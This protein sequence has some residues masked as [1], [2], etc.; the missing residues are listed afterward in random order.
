MADGDRPL[1]ALPRPDRVAARLPAAPRGGG[2]A[3]GPGKARQLERLSPQ[4]LQLQAALG[5]KRAALQ[6]DA[7][8]VAPELVLVF[9][10]NGPVAE[11]VD[12]VRA[13]PGLAWLA[14]EDLLDV[15]PDADFFIPKDPRK[16]L[17]ARLYMVMTNQAALDQLLSLWAGWKAN[18][19]LPK[20]L[21]GWRAVFAKLRNVRRWGTADRLAETGILRDWEDRKQFGASHI[22]VEVELWFRSAEQRGAAAERVSQ[23]V[24][25]A[26][27]Q[28]LQTA[29]LPDIAY[30]AVLARLPVDA[31]ERLLT[32]DGAALVKADDVRL[33]H[34]IPQARIV[35]SAAA[36]AED[37]R[38]S[39]PTAALGEPVV[40]LLDG[41]PVE[42][43][44]ELRGRL[45]VEDPDGWAATYPVGERFHGTAMASLILHGDLAAPGEPSDRRL[46]VRP[47]L[48]PD[49]WDR[50]SAPED[51]LWLD[52]VHRAIRRIIVGD[53][54]AGPSA[55]G[56]RI[57]NLSVGDAFQPFVDVAVSPLARLID[58]L[59]WEHDLLFIVSAGNHVT[60]LE[61][62]HGGEP[63]PEFEQ[64]V[65]RALQEDHRH[66]RLLSPAESVNAVTVGAAHQDEGGPLV[67]RYAEERLLVTTNGMPSPFSALG[68]G[69]RKAVKPDVLAPGGRMIYA[70]SIGANGPPLAFGPV[71]RS[72]EPPGQKVAAPT[73]RG[74]LYQ[75]GTSNAAALTTRSAE[76]LLRIVRQITAGSPHL[77]DL[78]EV[79]LLKALLVHTAE[80]P[81]GAVEVLE[82][83]LKTERN[84]HVFWDHV[85]A[86]VGYGLVH[87]DR[88]LACTADRV[89][90]LGGDTIGENETRL[91]R[92]PLPPGLNAF[93]GRRRLTVTLAWLSPIN[94]NHRKYRS[95]A[96][97][98]EPPIGE[99][100]PLRLEGLDVDLR[101]VRRGTVQHAVLERDAGA[102]NVGADDLLE[103]PVTCVFES[104]QG[105]GYVV[106]YG[107]AVSLEVA[108]GLAVSIYDEVRDRV[109]PRVPVRP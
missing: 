29:V 94:A 17:T 7:G 108:P 78:P 22:S 87:P 79:V 84:K 4:F 62:E 64:A 5:E 85:S 19:R 90:L 16:Q 9:E 40:A 2:G 60:V 55:P 92:V 46:Y 58:W 52:L 47:I 25:A 95:A 83:A 107:L 63:G 61:V 15:T 104:H 103:I 96:L 43:H 105:K 71:A 98:F 106:P 6:T 42:N 86:F 91:H 24:R 41:L 36:A 26:A 20:E 48:R 67:P 11:L 73:S 102:I 14:E 27:G 3:K 8:A 100:S 23:L 77:A 70:A 69:F 21:K 18:K 38:D 57:V 51:Q 45:T 75:S 32:G 93:T 50:E 12:A 13:T 35:R 97:S 66:R 54:G 72:L 65:L 59:A 68:R 28:V 99:R 101:A 89:T 80:W 33:F 88:A 34:P 49:T 56:V 31:V 1:L 30:H 10:T 109:R 82:R 74:T 44:P 39:T 81:A 53:A 76:R 37:A